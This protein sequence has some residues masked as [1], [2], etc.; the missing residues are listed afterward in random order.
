MLP[1]VIYDPSATPQLSASP[2]TVCFSD[3]LRWVSPAAAQSPQISAVLP[4]LSPSREHLF[5][6]RHAKACRSHEPPAANAVFDLSWLKWM[7]SC[8]EL[9]SSAR[10]NVTS[11]WKTIYL[12]VICW[13]GWLGRGQTTA[14]ELQMCTALSRLFLFS[15]LARSEGGG[16]NQN[17]CVGA[18][19]NTPLVALTA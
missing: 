9:I 4:S 8:L 10:V 6:T 12:T 19:F 7:M 1:A 16:Y 2:G 15:C 18:L 17:P 11:H 14:T 5:L 3:S 13:F